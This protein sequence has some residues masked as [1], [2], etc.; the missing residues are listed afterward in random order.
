MIPNQL[1]EEVTSLEKAGY[2]IQLSEAGNK[3]Y[4]HFKNFDLPQGY[5]IA[6]TDL[7]VFT[8]TAYPSAAFDMFW[9]NQELLLDGSRIPKAAQHIEPHIGK[10]WRRFS[11]H[12]YQ[13]HPWNPS[14]DSLEGYLTYVVKRLNHLV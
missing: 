8:S 10:T 9:V 6:K 14:E 5:N 7:L 13:Q 4:I 2:Q 3:V 11:I 1:Q 12:P